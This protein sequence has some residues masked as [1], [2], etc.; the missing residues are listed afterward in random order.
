[1]YYAIFGTK[2]LRLF[3]MGEGRVGLCGLLERD[4]TFD[5]LEPLSAC[6]GVLSSLACV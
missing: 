5:V 6:T 3:A 4:G 2:T 1:M